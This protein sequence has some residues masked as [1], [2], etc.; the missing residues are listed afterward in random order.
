MDEEENKELEYLKRKE[1]GLTPVR[2][3]ARA[4]AVFGYLGSRRN[5]PG[6]EAPVATL[7][8]VLYIRTLTTATPRRRD[9]I[10]K[11]TLIADKM[12]VVGAVMGGVGL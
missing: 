4:V 10:Q 11:A 9:V 7:S 1:S 3:A 12:G 5:A 8:G 6:R 2:G